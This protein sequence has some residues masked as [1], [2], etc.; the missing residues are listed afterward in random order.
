MKINFFPHNKKADIRKKKEKMLTFA[1][2]VVVFL[3]L[4]F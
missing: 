2:V 1:N 3:F 4:M